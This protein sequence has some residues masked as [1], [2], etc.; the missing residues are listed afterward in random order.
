M[1]SAKILC[2]DYFTQK[3]AVNVYRKRLHVQVKRINVKCSI[4]NRN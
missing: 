1:L 4:H 2:D 3:R